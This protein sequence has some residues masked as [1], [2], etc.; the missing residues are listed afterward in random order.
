MILDS[1]SL[2]SRSFLRFLHPVT[3]AVMIHLGSDS[4][5]LVGLRVYK[6]D[7]PFRLRYD[8]C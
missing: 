8:L 7:R 4:N 6:Y 1:F 2:G 5:L 3:F